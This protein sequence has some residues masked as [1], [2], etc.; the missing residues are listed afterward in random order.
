MAAREIEV[1][2]RDEDDGPVSEIR[3]IRLG[4]GAALLDMLMEMR[5]L[6]NWM[7]VRSVNWYASPM[8][9][10]NPREQTLRDTTFMVNR[11]GFDLFDDQYADTQ[12]HRLTLT[13][14]PVAA[15][16]AAGGRGQDG[17]R[18]CAPGVL[19]PGRP[20]RNGGAGAELAEMRGLLRDMNAVACR[21][22]EYKG[23][24]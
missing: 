16:V 9:D 6:V 12:T 1:S 20:A 22:V 21:R 10:W 15:P 19:D 17:R 2:I 11:F 18:R 24:E 14:A 5:P 4:Q 23:G 3:V 13:M 8:L 7:N